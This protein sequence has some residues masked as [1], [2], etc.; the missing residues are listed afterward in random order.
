[1]TK[2]VLKK[3]H[4]YNGSMQKPG[5]TS[6]WQVTQVRSKENFHYSG[7]ETAQKC[8]SVVHYE[9]LIKNM[10]GVLI[11]NAL[12]SSSQFTFIAINRQRMQE[13]SALMLPKQQQPIQTVAYLI[14]G[15]PI[16]PRPH[17]LH[18]CHI[19]ILKG[20]M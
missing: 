16:D 14:L 6:H 7:V 9:Q 18:S 2:N 1:M 5:A 3:Q 4:D 19:S 11:Y 8:I 13:D 15:A 12:L 20:K 17:L 10:L